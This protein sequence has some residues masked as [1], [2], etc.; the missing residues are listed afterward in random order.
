[1]YCDGVIIRVLWLHIQVK[2]C[3]WKGYGQILCVY[4]YCVSKRSWK[5]CHYQSDQ[6]H[7][8]RRKLQTSGLYVRHVRPIKNIIYLSVMWTSVPWFKWEVV[9]GVEETPCRG[10]LGHMLANRA[11]VYPSQGGRYCAEGCMALG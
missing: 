3:T 6:D 2:L 1:L 7:Y 11:P 10:S 4:W 5:V 8:I 9:T